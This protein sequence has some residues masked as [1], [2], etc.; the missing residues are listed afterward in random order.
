MRYFK[1]DSPTLPDTAEQKQRFAVLTKAEKKVR[2][3]DKLLTALAWIV[4][5]AVFLA[6]IALGQ[7]T[8][9]RIVDKIFAFFGD[10]SVGWGIVSVIVV[11]VFTV[12]F[13]FGALIIS[14]L[15][16]IVAALPFWSF[17]T[18][19]QHEKVK[20]ERRELLSDSCAFLREFYGFQEPCVVTK[21]YD[22]SDKR[23]KDHDICL[24]IVDGELRLT[25]NLQYGFMDMRRDL[26]CYAFEPGELQ[27]S[28]SRAGERPAVEVK[29]GE[30]TFLLGQR[31]R[32]FVEQNL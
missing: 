3:R 1:Y 19:T 12:C 20:R 2:R 26:G 32:T 7:W 24:F 18:K 15:I 21:C 28:E 11:F 9:S 10:E 5:V 4:G 13:M 6:L 31:A 25:T 27:L 29:A 14:S 23:F 30:V 17:V 8:H 22:S 16:A